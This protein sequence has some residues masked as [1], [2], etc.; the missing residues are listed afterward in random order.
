[1]K[2]V[3]ITYASFGSGHKTVAE[4]VYD[5]FKENGSDYEVKN[6]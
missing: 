5:Y 6:L 2:K 3:L 1:M 4:Y